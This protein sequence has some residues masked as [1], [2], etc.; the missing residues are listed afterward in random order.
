MSAS[1]ATSITSKSEKSG[2]RMTGWKCFA[3][4]RQ[5]V[6]VPSGRLQPAPRRIAEAPA[7]SAF[8]PHRCPF[9]LM[10]TKSIRFPTH[11]GLNLEHF[12]F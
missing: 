9:M 7:G 12:R 1:Y 6:G 4:Q 5:K 3:D 11:R 10:A 2:R 8:A